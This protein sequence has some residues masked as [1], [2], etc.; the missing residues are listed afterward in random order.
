MTMRIHPSQAVQQR[1][2]PV[3]EGMS[4]AEAWT[5]TV[6]TATALVIAGVA[7]SNAIAQ[8]L[9]KVITPPEVTNDPNGLNL[10]TGKVMSQR[11]GLSI[12]AAPRLTYTRASDFLMYMEG[13]RNITSKNGYYAVHYGGDR[14]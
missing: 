2:F 4:R 3:G 12:P 5:K 6:A 14:S 7:P 10:L 1:Q 8:E 9:P 13:Q 11:P